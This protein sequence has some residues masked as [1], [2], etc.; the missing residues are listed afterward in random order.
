MQSSSISNLYNLNK[1]EKCFYSFEIPHV[2]YQN[3]QVASTNIVMNGNKNDDFIDYCFTQLHFYGGHLNGILTKIGEKVNEK[4]KTAI[5]I[6]LNGMPHPK[7]A[8]VDM[9]NPIMP[10]DNMFKFLK[11]ITKNLVGHWPIYTA[12]TFGG[13]LLYYGLKRYS[14]VEPQL[15]LECICNNTGIPTIVILGDMNDPLIRSQV[16]DLYRRGYMIILISRQNNKIKMRYQNETD[17]L[18]FIDLTQLKD[19]RQL[20][21]WLLSEKFAIC[22]ILFIPNLSYYSTGETSIETT[23]NEIN[24]NILYQYD[25]LLQIIHLLKLSSS[26]STDNNG[27]KKYQLITFNSSIPKNL[28][29]SQHPIEIIISGMIQSVYQNLTTYNKTLELNM[30]NVGLLQIRGQL[31]NYKYLSSSGEDTYRALHEPIYQLIRKFNGNWLQRFL[32]H[33]KRVFLGNKFYMGR[34]SY[35]SAVPFVN[36]LLK[37]KLGLM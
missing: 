29:L 3:L 12:I 10:L 27:T 14:F 16:M 9:K 21:N 4:H 36:T 5:D 26:S 32:L 17:F 30:V 1:I 24:N 34:Y 11:P 37:I 35:I 15:P 33:L 18:K 31:S 28:N 2:N 7:N 6:I 19:Q 25:N 8:A 22:S 13:G 23:Q 20:K